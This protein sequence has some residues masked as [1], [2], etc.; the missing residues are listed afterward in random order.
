MWFFEQLAPGNPAYN[1]SEAFRIEGPLDVAALQQAVDHIVARHDAL[2]TVFTEIEGEPFQRALTEANAPIRSVDAP[3]PRLDPAGLELLLR[4]EAQRPFDFASP[5][6]MRVTLFRTGGSHVLQLTCHHIISDGWT[7]GNIYR[8]LSEL[9][10][11]LVRG[12]PPPLEPLPFGFT[13]FAVWQRE[14]LSG[15]AREKQRRF[16][17]ERLG[18]EP[19]YVELPADKPRPP[20]QGYRGARLRTTIE[21]STVEGLRRLA[22]EGDASFFMVLAAAYAAL[23]H[24]YCGQDEV[25]FGFPAAG[26]M[27]PETHGVLG[28]FVNSVILGTDC[29]GD[30]SF[31]EH[32]ARVRESALAAYDNQDYPFMHLVRELRPERGSTRPPFFST[33][34]TLV[35]RR[36]QHLALEGASVETL[37]FDP[38][39]SLL[40]LSIV[41]RE[42]ERGLICIFEYDLDLFEAAT[43][44]RMQDHFR[45]VLEHAVAAPE[46]PLSR[47]ALL[48]EAERTQLDSW[49]GTYDETAAATCVQELFE[50]QARR[51]PGGVAL[52]AGDCELSYAELNARANALARRLRELGVGR[53][54]LVA[55]DV[56][57]SVEMLVGLLAILKAGGAY[58]PLDLDDPLDRIN[59]LVDDAQLAFALARSERAL[60]LDAV[61]HG[62]LITLDG[63]SAAPDPSEARDLP[64]LA[65][66][67]S[68]AYVIY[69]SGSTGKPKGVLVEHRGLTNHMLWMM[70]AGLIAPGARMLHKATLTF[71]A[72]SS[73]TLAPL[74]A[75]GTVVLA[76]ADGHKDAAY[77]VDLMREHRVTVLDAVPSMLQLMLEEPGFAE[78]TS[79]RCVLTGGEAVW[80]GLVERF[81]AR[82]QATL[83]NCY[84]PTETTIESTFTRL[85]AGDARVPIGRPIDNTL[86]YVLDRSRNLAPI[87]IPGELYI[88]G[89]GVARGYLNRRKLTAQRFILN[90]FGPGRLYAT[91]DRVRFLPDGKL[92]F[93]GRFDDQVK[94]RGKRVELGE[95]ESV[96][97]KH[98]AVGAC[99]VAVREKAQGER[100]LV[101]YVVPADGERPDWAA[102]RASL[103]AKLP[104][105]MVPAL[106]A[107]LPEIP[108]TKSGK[109]SRRELPEPE[110]AALTRRDHAAP[111]TETERRLARIWERLLGVEGIGRFDD[112]FE[113]GGHSLL[114]VRL[115][116]QIGREFGK[117]I[118]LATLMVDPTIAHVALVLGACAEPQASPLTILNQGG[119]QPPFIYFHNDLA[120]GGLYCRKIAEGLG[121]D[122]PFYAIDPHGG[123]G[124]VPGSIEAM[125]ADYLPLVRS[126]RPRGPYRLGGF[127]AGG[128]VAYEIAQSLLRQGERVE[129]LVLINTAAPSARVPW[130]DGAI[131][132]IGRERRLAPNLRDRLS[133]ILAGRVRRIVSAFSRGPGPGLEALREQLETLRMRHASP[134]DGVGDAIPEPW[135][136]LAV[137]S[138]TYHPKPYGGELTLMWGE[139]KGRHVASDPA[140][141]W[142]ALS[143]A[144]TLIPI[145]GDHLSGIERAGAVI[146]ARLRERLSAKQ[147]GSA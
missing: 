138:Y 87:G 39:I 121:R 4:E 116:A 33:M 93:L 98:P 101:A 141:G 13:D 126:I 35:D 105:H 89:I 72:A 144:A 111:S 24:R 80:A 51:N 145:P 139:E 44:E 31:A 15:P 48:S 71:D 118:P 86:I 22:R 54:S 37:R 122:Q 19:A 82:S 40:D 9:Y 84:G 112:F 27:L 46:T 62:T 90:P 91:G 81:Y 42:T 69:T 55:L 132:L 131:R 21:P 26:R 28:C 53:D 34:L 30:P 129:H 95:I 45:S 108:R 8:E 125:A 113:L 97:R 5:P 79:L 83:Y 29:S 41:L 58:V 135:V 68:L 6:L 106:W 88:G 103:A 65:D 60:K 134:A 10:G 137:A 61:F 52:I 133:L 14:L 67:D 63:A 25:N 100:K 11:A 47:L 3:D 140:M 99:A 94:I 12:E 16:W 18:D 110:A 142:G 77:L 23:L 102:L 7:H 146:G 78:C 66:A 38:G 127:C 120:G 143:R 70:N 104:A 123:D 32:V 85:E 50:T 114:A 128:T 119:S 59:Y 36:R 73:E 147:P 109:L 107:A 74:V 1:T 57:R 130:I 43:I 96:L 92:E 2:R 49:S 20:K 136:A 115:V 76:K 75:G 17:L 124:V 64:P 56:E 117:R